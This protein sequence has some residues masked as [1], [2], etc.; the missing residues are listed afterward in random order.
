MLAKHNSRTMRCKRYICRE[1]QPI[2]AITFTNP[3]DFDKDFVKA[4]ENTVIAKHPMELMMKAITK[5]KDALPISDI[6]L[7]ATANTNGE[8]SIRKNLYHPD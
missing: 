1:L 8:I 4:L 5:L 7:L 3:F 6:F 2:H